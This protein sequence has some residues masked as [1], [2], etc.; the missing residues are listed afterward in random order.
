MIA[1]DELH[2]ARNATHNVRTLLKNLSSNN[3]GVHAKRHECNLSALNYRECGIV[4]IGVF[5]HAIEVEFRLACVY[6]A[7]IT[8]LCAYVTA[9]AVAAPAPEPFFVGKDLFRGKI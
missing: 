8:D 7:A 6:T 9:S 4:C 2:A 3:S 5:I 1:V